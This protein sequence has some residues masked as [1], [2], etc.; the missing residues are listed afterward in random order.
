MYLTTKMQLRGLSVSEYAAL[1]AMC[2]LTKNL[3]NEGLYS[4]RQYFFLEGK[5][6]RYEGNY[7]ACKG[8]ENY[9][10]L[11]T[12]I[13][14]QTLKVVDRSFKSFFALIKKAQSGGYQFNQIRIPHY[15]PKDGFFPL[16]IPRIRVKDGAFTVP[17]TKAFR[18]SY[19]SI[20]VTV[21]PQ[22]LGQKIQ[23]VRIHP[24]QNAR[25]FEAEFVYE[26][27]EFLHDLDGTKY[28]GID[29]GLD[30]LPSLKIFFF[31]LES[32]HSETVSQPAQTESSHQ[33]RHECRRIP[34]YP[35]LR[36]KPNWDCCVRL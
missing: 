2:R 1:R 4:V 24:K 17:T 32:I 11:N 23:E 20:R 7:H 21:P 26:K 8:S 34:H 15:L 5:Y 14:Q 19:G 9:A 12:D 31:L 10:L 30:N 33:P 3:Y 36:R 16:I 22:L 35:I 18:E 6:L 25:F 13:A 29:L 27:E 28:L